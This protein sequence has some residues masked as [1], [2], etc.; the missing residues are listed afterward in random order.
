MGMTGFGGTKVENPL[1]YLLNMKVNSII[2][3]EDYIQI[4]FNGPILTAY[5]WPV[6]QMDGHTYTTD[7]LGYRNKL[8]SL[9][10]KKVIRAE[11]KNDNYIK[12]EFVNDINF[13]ISLAENESVIG[14]EFATFSLND[15]KI[16][17]WN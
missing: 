2:F 7:D 10:G 13:T 5:V 8:C 9:I 4:T 12:L 14:P 17:V 16:W 15:D 11:F 1:N 3:I 6:I